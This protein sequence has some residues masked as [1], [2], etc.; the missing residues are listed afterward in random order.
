MCDL[1]GIKLRTAVV[2][3]GE[4][5][6]PGLAV[7][8]PCPPQAQF[9]HAQG[10]LDPPVHFQNKVAAEGAALWVWARLF[11]PGGW[12]LLTFTQGGAWGLLPGQQEPGAPDQDIGMPF[13]FLLWP[14]R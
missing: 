4:K 6:P 7:P 8:N 12:G 1:S 13:H 10:L 11:P 9:G 5:Q 2:I 14:Q 3:T